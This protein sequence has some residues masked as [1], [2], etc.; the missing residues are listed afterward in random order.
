LLEVLIQCSEENKVQR[1]KLLFTQDFEVDT[2][3]SL[4]SLVEESRY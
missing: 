2:I 4:A 3:A 1:M